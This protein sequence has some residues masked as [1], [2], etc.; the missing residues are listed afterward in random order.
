MCKLL[1]GNVSKKRENHT[2]LNV[3]SRSLFEHLQLNFPSIRSNR[4]TT[5]FAWEDKIYVNKG[6]R[7]ASK[8]SF[9]NEGKLECIIDEWIWKL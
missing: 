4:N 1:L 5:L 9:Q 7:W 2:N 3:H 8:F 6:L